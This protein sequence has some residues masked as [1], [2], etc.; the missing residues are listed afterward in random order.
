MTYSLPHYWEKD[1][2][3]PFKMPHPTSTLTKR[4]APFLKE[5]IH[6]K[7]ASKPME[8][9]MTSVTI[10]SNSKTLIFSSLAN[11]HHKTTSLSKV[12]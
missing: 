10:A 2:P 5:G 9:N 6:F 12:I 1:L 11:I 3:D 7:K 8:N 4:F